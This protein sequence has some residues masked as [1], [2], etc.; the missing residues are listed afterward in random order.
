MIRF[1]IMNSPMKSKTQL[2]QV[3]TLI[4][5]GLISF[6]VV[7][8]GPRFHQFRAVDIVLLLATGLCF[9]VALCSLL[10]RRKE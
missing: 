2:T 4:G 9:G 1:Y 3:F 7:A 8:H 10:R 5:I 6:Y